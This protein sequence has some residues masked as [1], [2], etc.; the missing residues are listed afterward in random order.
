MAICI[1]FDN[2]L[3][4]LQSK[5]G[6]LSLFE[7][8]KATAEAFCL[9]ASKKGPILLVETGNENRSILSYFGDPYSSLED[10]I[11]NIEPRFQPHGN[12]SYPLSHIFTIINKYRIRNKTD[13][14]G[15]GRLTR[16]QYLDPL[17]FNF[18]LHCLTSVYVCCSVCWN[19]LIFT[20]LQHV[21]VEMNR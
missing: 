13:N 16:C 20:C 10:A 12:L 19:R 3:E 1:V 21:N 7:K 17:I 11:R 15:H 8:L 14:F 9:A 2:C 18:N 6:E 4:Q 5:V